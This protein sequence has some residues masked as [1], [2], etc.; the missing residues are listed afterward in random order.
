VT[1]ETVSE[2]PAAPHQ[3]GDI[4]SISAALR[5]HTSELKA[6]T[7]TDGEVDTQAIADQVKGVERVVEEFIAF[8]GPLPLP[9]LLEDYDRVM[10]GLGKTIVGMAVSEL[11][12]RHSIDR[13]QMDM[14]RQQIALDRA[15]LELDQDLINMRWR[16]Q[17]IG[18][19]LVGIVIILGAALGFAGHNSVS[20]AFIGTGAAGI[21]GAFVNKRRLG[22]RRKPR[23]ETP[24]STEQ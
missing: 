19:A 14:D 2:A 9:V 21:A 8:S 7:T 4:E 15:A 18:A 22:S 10:P 3:R 23:P 16:G 17:E 24:R 1:E 20:I 11:E 12:H 6:L 5:E 13:H